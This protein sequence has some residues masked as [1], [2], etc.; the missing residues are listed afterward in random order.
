[1][2]TART[3]RDISTV[4]S[5]RQKARDK[6][7][8]KKNADDRRAAIGNKAFA[9]MSRPEKDDLLFLLCL[10]HGILPKETE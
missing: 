6:H 9:S 7:T 4:S 1:M 5:E 3:T 10:E 8:A 2:A